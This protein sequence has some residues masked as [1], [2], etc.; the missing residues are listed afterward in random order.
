M[1]CRE[2]SWLMRAMLS[3]SRSRISTNWPDCTL[4][5]SDYGI[6]SQAGDSIKPGWEQPG[7]PSGGRLGSCWSKDG[8]WVRGRVPGSAPVDSAVPVV[9]DEYPLGKTDGDVTV[10]VGVVL[11]GLTTMDTSEEGGGS[12]PS[13]PAVP[14]ELE[15]DREN[16]RLP[17]GN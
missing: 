8:Q 12:A 6:G 7:G 5:K 15:G 11:A 10:A 1:P 16:V 2:E 17:G 14:E 3:A 4:C 13:N 9:V